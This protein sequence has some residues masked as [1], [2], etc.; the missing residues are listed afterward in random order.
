[1]LSVIDSVIRD[2]LAFAGGGGLW[3]RS[4][5]AASMLIRRSRILRNSSRSRGGGI[6]NLGDL[7]LVATVVRDNDA[8]RGG[9][10]VYNGGGPD[11]FGGLD[12]LGTFAK[13]AGSSVTGNSPDDCV[14]TSAC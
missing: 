9:G 11:G 3:N 13:D 10:G 5:D 14:G 6:G 1:V 2:N 8:R 4:D 12:P 7:V